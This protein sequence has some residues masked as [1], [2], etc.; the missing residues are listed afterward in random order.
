[1]KEMPLARRAMPSSSGEAEEEIARS[2]LRPKIPGFYLR[3]L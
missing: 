1:M 2:L 3:T